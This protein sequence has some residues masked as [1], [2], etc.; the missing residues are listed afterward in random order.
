MTKLI[1]LNQSI[2]ENLHQ[3]SDNLSGGKRPDQA[4]M[5]RFS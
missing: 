3:K 5:R 4:F 1:K 2:D